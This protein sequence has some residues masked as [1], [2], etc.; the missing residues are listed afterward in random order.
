[1]EAVVTVNPPPPS[2]P[3]PPPLFLPSTCPPFPPSTVQDIKN[4]TLNFL[5]KVRGIDEGDIEMKIEEPCTF[6]VLRMF[7]LPK[8]F[9]ENSTNS[10][11]S[12]NSNNT[13]FFKI[14]FFKI[15]SIPN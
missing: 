12:K 5:V 6:V 14:Y 3:P 11:N 1:M 7:S 10:E 15:F 8:F 9:S 13:H 2:P 4:Q